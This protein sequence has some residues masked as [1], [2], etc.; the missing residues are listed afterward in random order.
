MN[1]SISHSMKLMKSKA[2]KRRVNEEGGAWMRT[3]SRRR[4]RS[5]RRRERREGTERRTYP[6]EENRFGDIEREMKVLYVSILVN[7][8]RRE[9]DQYRRGAH[10]EERR[11]PANSSDSSLLL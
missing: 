4:R 3:K 1:V 5:R 11:F 2:L 10:R 7:H 9:E 6:R 8:G